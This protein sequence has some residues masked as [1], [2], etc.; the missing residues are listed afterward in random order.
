MN[1]ESFL[2]GEKED[3]EEADL[4]GVYRQRKIGIAKQLIGAKQIA[5]EDVEK[6]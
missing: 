2:N 3:Y 5:R 6:L 4:G 1:V